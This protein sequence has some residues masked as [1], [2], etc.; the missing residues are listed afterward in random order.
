MVPPKKSIQPIHGQVQR[1]KANQ[2]RVFIAKVEERGPLQG[3]ST[4]SSVPQCP[5]FTQGHA[6]M[7]ETS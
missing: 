3:A 1:P 6:I 7:V 4:T 5:T 2:Q